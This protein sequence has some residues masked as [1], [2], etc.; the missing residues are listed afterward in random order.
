LKQIIITIQGF[1]E[2]PEGDIGQFAHEEH[3]LILTENDRFLGV[4]MCYQG[5]KPIEI[6]LPS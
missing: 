2:S 6:D 5:G 3:Q 4:I 1:E